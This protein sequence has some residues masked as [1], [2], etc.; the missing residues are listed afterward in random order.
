MNL[1]FLRS[2]MLC[3]G[4]VLLAGCATPGARSPLGIVAA[5]PALRVPVAREAPGGIPLQLVVAAPSG[6]ALIDG[7]RVVARPGDGSLAVL[8]GVRWAD[9]APR[10]IQ[11]ALVDALRR[12][13]F[14][15]VERQ[16]QGLRGDLQLNLQLRRFEVDYRDPAQAR[17][18]VELVAI[19]IH[20]A[21]GRAAASKQFAASESVGDRSASAGAQ[22]LLRAGSKALAETAEWVVQRALQESVSR[23]RSHGESAGG[24]S[25]RSDADT[26]VP[27]G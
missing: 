4:L 20:V 25:I 26:G 5:D 24:D 2:F 13:G 9:P 7:L 6:P 19:L 18:E 10:M 11:D 8:E 22:A 12:S 1:T 16:G 27:R 23:P 14:L 21:S 17:G 3:G 15:A